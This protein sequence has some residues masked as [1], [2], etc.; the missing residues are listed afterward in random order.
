[1]KQI[2]IVLFIL[3]GL[4]LAKDAVVVKVNQP[5]QLVLELSIDSTWISTDDQII[6]SIPTLDFYF[7]P[8]FPII[9]YYGE[10]LIGVPANA[11]IKVFSNNMELVGSFKPNILGPEKAKGIEFELPIK[12]QFDGY[13]PKQSVKLS[14][15]KN[16]SG[17]PSSKIEIFPF[18]IQDGNLFVTKNISIQITWNANIQNAPAKLLSKTSL[19][20]LKSQ[21]KL[22]KPTENIIPEYQFSNNIAKIVIDTSAWYRITNS[23]LLSNGIDFNGVNPNTIRLWNRENE[24]PLYIDNANE[25]I[26]SDNDLIVFY[27]EKNPSPDWADYDNNFYTDDNVYWLTWG[28]SE[29]KRFYEIDVLP[30]LP[31]SL[32]YIPENYKLNKKIERDDEYVRLNRLNQ[33]LLQT[34][35][36]IDHFYMSPKIIVGKPFE[37]EFELDSPD[38]LSNKG[39]DLE[40][41]V[42]GMTTSEH[43]LDVKIND[44]L[45]TNANWTDRN[46]LRIKQ[47]AINS[48]NLKNGKNVLSLILSPDDAT[49]HD[50]I[51][52]NWYKIKYPRYFQTNNDY[53]EFSSDSIPDKT[54]QFE[55]TGFSNSDILL[56]KNREIVLS[57]FQLLYESESD[58]YLLK[59]QDDDAQLSSQYEAV[60]HEKLLNVKSITLESAIINQLSNIRSSYVVLAPDSFASTL[61]P[62]I[63]YHNGT[64]VDVDKI[65]RQY[66]YGILSPYAIKEFL[67]N[68]YMQNGSTLEYAVIAMTSNLNDWRSGA[69]GRPPSIPA[70]SIYTYNMG[71]VACDYWYSVF[72]E[73]YW[74]PNI[75]VSRFPVSNKAELQIIVNKTLYHHSR[76][77][78]NWDNNSLLIADAEAQFRFQSEAMVNKIKN[79]GTF[80]SRLYTDPFLPYSSFYGTKD[81][82]LNH[83][84]RGLA[85]INFVGHGGGAVWGYDGQTLGHILH[86][87]D[88][89]EI[90]NHNKLP[91][92]TSMTCFT[93]DFSFSYGLGNLMLANENGGALAWYGSSGLGWSYNDFYL[94]EPLQDLLFSDEDMTIGEIINLSKTQYYLFYYDIYPEIAASQIYQYNLI[95]DPAI[96]VKKPIKGNVQISPLDPEPG[97][98]IEISSNNSQVDSVFYQI[99]LPDNYSLNQSTLLGNTLPE[100]LS[101]P[102]TFSKGIHSINLSYK[103][104]NLLYNSSQLLSVAGSYVNIQSTIPS[105]PTICDSIGVIAEVSDRSGIS[106]VQLIWN[107][108]YWAEMVNIDSNLY[109][110][111]KLIPPQP[112]GTVLNL[113]CQVIDTNNDT[114]NS[115]PKIVSISDIPNI[116]PLKGAFRV[117]GNINL[118][119]DIESTTTTPVSANVELF[120]YDNDV[121]KLLGRVTVDFNGMETKE[122]IFPNYYPF[123]TNQY[124]VVTNANLT[125]MS[126]ELVTDDTLTFNLETNA[127]WVT[128]QL[129]STDDGMTHS[130]VG[131]NN[132][133]IDIP[134]GLITERSI[135]QILPITDVLIPSQP[136]FEAIQD[137][138]HYNGIDIIWEATSDYNINW[139]IGKSAV[140]LNN[141]LYRYFEEFRIWLPITYTEVSDSTIIIP[142]NGSAKFAFLKNTDVE[143]PTITATINDQQ[144]LRN[145]YLNTNPSIQFT[146]YDKN[147]VDYRADSISFWINNNIMDELISEMSGNGNALNIT[148]NPILTKFDSTLAVLVQDAAGIRSDTLQLSFIV[149]EQLDLID[150]G[151]FPNPF[152]ESTIF[153]YELTETVEK[154]T[155][156]IY[157][158]DG[159]KVRI[160]D[161]DNII[162]GL[163][164]N[165]AGYHEIEW[166]GKNQDGIA[167]GNGNYF[168]QIRV[169]NNKTVIER[170]GKILRAQ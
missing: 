18:S 7:Q 102:D 57:N 59:F 160:L 131:I 150:Y 11:V 156:T 113:V 149:S 98:E 29:G 24:I 45:I 35:D 118:V 13:F 157:T 114:T 162:S 71:T 140:Q 60:S 96:K 116:L 112:S 82:L 67:E 33:Y 166:D 142:S 109:S 128:P 145:N 146:I 28:A 93:G 144:F 52:L 19:N 123:G 94:V 97:E 111:E 121:W 83:L 122:A 141:K 115:L 66:S 163:N 9:P 80:L 81:T 6:H 167:V 53:I 17:Q 138:Q 92:I 88:M 38:T 61:T 42:R 134:A 74:I 73:E 169:K 124:K 14:P 23:E 36:V 136:D 168:Y 100:F 55:I 12:N 20:E 87:N 139:I 21:K 152:A 126:T 108:E 151:N 63:D 127:F 48:G 10:V 26:F 30:L 137:Q 15:I 75:S 119:V 105:T 64:L 95:G 84:N 86:R 40:I 147:G 37:F 50:L 39:F 8:G 32:V 44:Q 5:G 79:N 3:S 154:L 25:A 164:L 104:D 31:D 90:S 56:F 129:G 47:S 117:D 170:N 62:L 165:L 135:L 49:L 43:S 34:W 101:L 103:S 41:Q 70:M 16:V 65:Y 143:K 78:N 89:D 153:A 68:I 161:N 69:I 4:I 77:I 133:E 158:V 51:Y 22:Q 159:R 46:T 85:Y 76:D 2:F 91:F 130:K 132:V 58:D 148:V 1:M 107:G 27:G 125:C 110:L 106:S 120:L 72:D 155:I 99:F 54:V